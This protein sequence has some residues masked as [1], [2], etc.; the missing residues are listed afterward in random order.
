MNIDGEPTYKCLTCQD[1]GLA[2]V[3]NP[4]FVEAYRGE[5][6]TV[7]RKEA[8]RKPEEHKK[9]GSLKRLAWDLDKYDP[10]GEI[11]AWRYDPPN[12]EYLANRW[13]HKRTKGKGG[14]LHYVA[15]C[16]CECERKLRLENELHLF[17][18]GK[19]EV[20]N[21]RTGKIDKMGMPACGR[22]KYD[23]RTMPIKTFNSFDDL[24]NWYATVEVNEVYAWQ[25]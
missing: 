25:P 24:E 23:P 15:L 6:E 8:P 3:W 17:L 1:T 5:F 21:T 9:I 20:K 10:K 14:A 18:S 16:N 13:W 4:R 11:T 12:W 22:A 7:N 19:R 2:N